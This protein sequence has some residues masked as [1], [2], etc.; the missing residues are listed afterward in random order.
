MTRDERWLLDEK[1]GGVATPQFEADCARL[2]TGEPLGYVIGWQPFL[3]LRISLNSHP[4]IPRVET[5]WWAE[6]LLSAYAPDSWAGHSAVALRAAR[7]S[8]T[9]ASRPAVE[10]PVA[11]LDLCAGSGAIGCAALKMLPTAE[12]YFG[13]ID[14]THRATIE[15]NICENNL[16]NSRAHI[17]IGD[18]FEPFAGKRFDIIACNP[19][20]IPMERPLDQSVSDYE[21]ALALRSGTDGLDLMRRI[22]S[23]LPNHLSPHGVAWIECDSLHADA[24]RSL[25][26][27]AGLQATIR[28]DQYHAP[29]FLVVSLP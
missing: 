3:G 7:P 24:A 28:T 15:K 19:P 8:L 13:E 16:D 14:A 2:A 18:L 5:E 11:L 9:T 1:Y 25:F 22:A 26:E 20:Y 23:E 21:P 6:K 27:A 10:S 12:V 4:L 29:R 17:G